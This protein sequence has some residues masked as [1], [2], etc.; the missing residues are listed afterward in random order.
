[1]NETVAA[2]F[3]TVADGDVGDPGT[4]EG[5]M[6]PA[7]VAFETPDEFSA[8]AEKLYA[9][10]FVRPATVHEVA[11][12]ITWHVPALCPVVTL[13]AVTVKLVG[14]P[15]VPAPVPTEIVTEPLDAVSVSVGASGTSGTQTAKSAVFTTGVIVSLGSISVLPVDHASNVKRLREMPVLG[16]TVTVVLGATI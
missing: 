12:E 3:S 2:P 1:V 6:G 10:P 14:N 15:P 5:V 11:G 9:A 7:S 8:T 4:V 16:A 13:I